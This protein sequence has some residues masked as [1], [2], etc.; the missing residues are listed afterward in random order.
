LLVA[1]QRR[2]PLDV[3]AGSFRLTRK[4]G[5]AILGMLVLVVIAGLVVTRVAIM[6]LGIVISLL[7]GGDLERLLLAILTS[8][9]GAAFAVVLT[10]LYAAIYRALAGAETSTARVFE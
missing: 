5:W 2:N 4:R 1:E 10:V 9:I 3:I 6:L 7:T 8:G